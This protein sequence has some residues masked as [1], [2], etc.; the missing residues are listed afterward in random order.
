[1]VH[2]EQITRATASKFD[3]RAGALSSRFS[4]RPRGFHSRRL[5]S[6]IAHQTLCATKSI[7]AGPTV[8]R[9]SPL[10]PCKSSNAGP[11]QAMEL[12]AR[13]AGESLTA[14]GQPVNSR[15]CDGPLSQPGGSGS[16]CWTAWSGRARQ[17]QRIRCQYDAQSNRLSRNLLYRQPRRFAKHIAEQIADHRDSI[18][19]ARPVAG[20]ASWAGGAR[21]SRWRR[22]RP[23]RRD[24]PLFPQTAGRR[25][26]WRSAAPA[27]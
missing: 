17:A 21:R 18:S 20:A 19:P 26:A 2:E 7:D 3:Q 12:N 15:L 9:R 8:L 27:R 22:N 13:R 5:F 14:A 25:S 6:G 23:V 10:T 24:R 4:W 16:G 1:M 11:G